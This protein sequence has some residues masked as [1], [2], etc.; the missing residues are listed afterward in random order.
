MYKSEGIF[1]FYYNGWTFLA[2][3][4]VESLFNSNYFGGNSFDQKYINHMIEWG[5]TFCDVQ[6]YLHYDRSENLNAFYRVLNGTLFYGEYYSEDYSKKHGR[7]P[8]NLKHLSEVEAATAASEWSYDPDFLRYQKET[9]D[10]NII[11][12]KTAGK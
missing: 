8:K 10:N 9:V 7:L 6:L 5:K 11:I 12:A 2:G 3:P 1:V 4:K